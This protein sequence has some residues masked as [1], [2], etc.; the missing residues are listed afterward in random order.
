MAGNEIKHC[1]ILFIPGLVFLFS[2][3][4]IV[5]QLI[6]KSLPALVSIIIPSLLAFVRLYI[7]CGCYLC[8]TL[9][10]F[11]IWKTDLNSAGEVLE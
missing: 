11:F 9:L 10:L 1:P 3:I 6:G 7:M 4:F 8:Q 5:N 2:F